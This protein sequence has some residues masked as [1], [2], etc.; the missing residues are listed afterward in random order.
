ME[1]SFHGSPLKVVFIDV[2]PV[3]LFVT[4]PSGHCF[5]LVGIKDAILKENIKL[6]LPLI[7]TMLLLLRSTVL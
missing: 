2:E 5:T 3:S 7:A 6:G 1:D 4:F